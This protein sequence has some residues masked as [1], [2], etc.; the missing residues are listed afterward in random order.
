MTRG[1]GIGYAKN[2]RASALCSV[3]G[4]DKTVID[5]KLGHT[6]LVTIAGVG[7][8]AD[9]EFCGAGG[10]SSH[11]RDISLVVSSTQNQIFLNAQ[12]RHQDTHASG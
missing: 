2:C 9:E 6:R 1:L 5:W 10:V 8:F 4:I 3:G 7:L 12:A 11:I